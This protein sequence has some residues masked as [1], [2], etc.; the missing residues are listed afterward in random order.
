MADTWRTTRAST[1]RGCSC[2]KVIYDSRG[3]AHRAKDHAQCRQVYRC[4]DG[5]GWHLSSMSRA[6]QRAARKRRR[7]RERER[8][9][10]ADG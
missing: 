4:P 10:V 8:V 5:H 3:D 6:E 2:G 7:E 9:A 1:W